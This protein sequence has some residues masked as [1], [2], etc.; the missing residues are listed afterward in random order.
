M[1]DWREQGIEADVDAIHQKTQEAMQRAN[2]SVTKPVLTAAGIGTVLMFVVSPL[3]GATVGAGLVVAAGIRYGL[4]V[5]RIV[6]DADRGMTMVRSRAAD[7]LASQQASE[8]SID[9]SRL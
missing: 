2:R 8:S 9:L 1:S 3:A 5:R 4:K 7:R 6:K